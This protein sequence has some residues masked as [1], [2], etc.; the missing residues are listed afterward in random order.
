MAQIRLTTMALMPSKTSLDYERLIPNQIHK[1]VWVDQPLNQLIKSGKP[2]PSS[3]NQQFVYIFKQE[4]GSH[5]TTVSFYFLIIRKCT[6]S[7]QVS[8]TEL[9]HSSVQQRK[10][11]T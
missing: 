5:Q 6:V 11:D 8:L 1:E 7:V 9:C 2:G 3:L 4:T 10:P